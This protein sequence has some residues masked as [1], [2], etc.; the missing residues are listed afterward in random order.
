MEG[1]RLAVSSLKGEAA[2]NSESFG[3]QKA[4]HQARGY[5]YTHNHWLAY[6]PAF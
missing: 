5:G 4:G 6:S 2:L 3:M 1:E